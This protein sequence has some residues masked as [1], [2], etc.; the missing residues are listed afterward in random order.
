MGAR[1][2]EEQ[3]NGH[4]RE[5]R[6]QRIFLRPP[7]LRNGGKRAREKRYVRA[8]SKEIKDTSLSDVAYEIVDFTAIVL[9]RKA[10]EGSF[11]R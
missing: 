4:A 1:E 9:F 7:C 2:H 3:Q 11:E 5:S 8:N 6:A 10:F